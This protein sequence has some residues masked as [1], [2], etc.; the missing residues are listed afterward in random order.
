MR[1]CHDDR[2]K[3]NDLSP[4]TSHSVLLCWNVLMHCNPPNFRSRTLRIQRSSP[5]H[6]IWDYSLGFGR[7]IP[8]RRSR[9]SSGTDRN[10]TGRMWCEAACQRIKHIAWTQHSPLPKM[11]VCRQNVTRALPVGRS[12]RAVSRQPPRAR[13]GWLHISRSDHS[14]EELAATEWQPA[15]SAVAAGR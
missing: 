8:D 15:G 12:E 3:E 14:G 5:S 4:A 1:A 2:G 9:L 7:V 6:G 11:L 13:A 10:P